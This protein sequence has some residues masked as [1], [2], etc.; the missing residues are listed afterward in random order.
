[1]L[2]A[3]WATDVGGQLLTLPVVVIGIRTIAPVLSRW[4]G[5][6][7][8]TFIFQAS[9]LRAMAAWLSLSAMVRI[10]AA[11]LAARVVWSISKAGDAFPTTVDVPPRPDL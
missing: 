10:A 6:G 4:T 2:A 3:W 7:T 11:I 5:T 1:M 8:P 9:D